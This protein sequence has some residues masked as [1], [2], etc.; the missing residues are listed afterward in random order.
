MLHARIVNL[1][2]LLAVALGLV[3]ACTTSESSNG[4]G[5]PT[6]DGG[7][8]AEGGGDGGGGDSGP[9]TPE[10]AACDAYQ[11]A[12]NALIAKC[13][14]NLSPAVTPEGASY[15]KV[16]NRKFCLA[17]LA[18]PGTGVTAQN[19]ADCAKVFDAAK[20][21]C[22]KAGQ[23][24]NDPQL[25]K[26]FGKTGFGQTGSLDDGMPCRSG[27]QCKGG[28]CTHPNSFVPGGLSTDNSTCNITNGTCHTGVAVGQSCNND[29]GIVCAFS[30][31]CITGVCVANNTVAVGGDCNTSTVGA[32]GHNCVAGLACSAG[33]CVAPGD[34]A[35]PCAGSASCK[36]GLVCDKNVCTQGIPL[37]ADCSQTPV[38][39][40]DSVCAPPA[41]KCTGGGTLVLPGEA[42]GLLNGGIVGCIAGNCLDGECRTV[43][44][45]GQPCTSGDKMNTCD[46]LANCNKGVCVLDSPICR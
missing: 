45:D 37:G 44:P 40:I 10:A 2:G 4:G 29:T 8:A 24:E 32:S 42:C 34:A 15:Q 35:A 1:G 18:L 6:A 46:L 14:P 16:R 28:L 27:A 19:L 22:D 12:V 17:E 39:C 23:I 26:C 41:M 36:K 38:L 25:S 11:D 21:S 31:D 7:G 9:T 33:K 3:A 13:T 5:I 20:V 43:I 30:A